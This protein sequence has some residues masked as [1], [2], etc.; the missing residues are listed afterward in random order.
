M[1]AKLFDETNYIFGVMKCKD[2]GFENFSSKC[3]GRKG[4]VARGSYY[5][6]TP[7]I[8]C[9]TPDLKHFFELDSR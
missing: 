2:K 3:H 4:M 7:N 8:S 9:V 1:V 6:H 5:T